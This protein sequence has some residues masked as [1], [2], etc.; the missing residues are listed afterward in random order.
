[1][2][3][4]GAA[5]AHLLADEI[6]A[7]GVPVIVHPTMA[8]RRG[9]REP[10][11]G[12]RGAAAKAGIPVALQSGFEGYV[13]KTRVV[14]FE[15]AW[16]RRAGLGFDAALAPSP[17]TR[18][19]CSASTAASARCG[20]QGRRPGALRRRPVRVHHARVRPW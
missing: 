7:A 14:L 8:V 15:A 12:E 19:G 5:E 3:L 10:D 16:P 6:K 20:R 9:C 13:P 11:A 4:D 1:V 17:S 2:V 18:R